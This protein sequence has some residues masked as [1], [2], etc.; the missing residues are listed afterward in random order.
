MDNAARMPAREGMPTS[1]MRRHADLVNP[2]EPTATQGREMLEDH[3]SSLAQPLREMGEPM[4]VLDAKVS[5]PD[6][7]RRGRQG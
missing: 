1:E 5:P 6:A 3:R 2:G 7:R 4:P